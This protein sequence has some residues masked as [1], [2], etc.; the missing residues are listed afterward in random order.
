MPGSSFQRQMHRNPRAVVGVFLLLMV[1]CVLGLVAWKAS[2]ARQATLRQA[3]GNLENLT[4]S[5]SQHAASTIKAPDVALGGMADLLKYQAPLEERFNAYLRDQTHAMPQLHFIAVFDRGG[6]WRYSSLKERPAYTNADRPYFA[7]HRENSST[8]LLVSGPVTSRLTGLPTIILSR[9]VSTP[10]GQFAGVIVA[11]IDCEFFSSFFGS[12]DVGTQGGISILKTDGTLLT[13]WP[14]TGTIQT[15][16]DTTVFQRRMSE[17]ASGFYRVT[18]PFDGLLKYVG[19]EQTADYPLVVTVARSE[20]EVLNDW[21]SDL[22]SDALVAGLLLAV[23][24]GVAG[25]LDAQ[26]RF[27]KRIE[28][29]LQDREARFRLGHSLGTAG[30]SFS[31]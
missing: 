1:G 21:R 27:G 6:D 18:S 4:R 8:K 7:Y 23:V 20:A 11:A 28:R 5:L 16:G 10:T 26:F 30:A 3:R 29:F 25:L 22:A 31:K 24:V 14:A 2:N 17:S 9:R 13:R 19:Y 12:F 15:L